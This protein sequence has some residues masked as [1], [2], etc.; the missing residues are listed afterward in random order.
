VADPARERSV[1]RYF[2]LADSFVQI[3]LTEGGPLDL[4]S[5]PGLNR[6]SYRRL[7]IE[8]CMPEFREDVAASIE[9]LFPEDPLMVEDLL[10]RLCVEINPAL[11]IHEVRL[12]VSPSTHAEQSTESPVAGPAVDTGRLARRAAALEAN[13]SKA[14]MGQ[15]RAVAAVARAVRKAAVGL[16]GEDRPLASF[17]FAG[18]TG[19][20]KTELARTLARQIFSEPGS[21]RGTGLVRVDCSEFALAHD[22][23]KLIG[24]PPGYVGHEEG[25]Q[26][27]EAVARTP[28]CVVLF[29]EIEKAHPRLH[30]LL[31]QVLE[32]G[33]LTDSKGQRVSF[34]RTIV[35]LTTNAGA[36]EMRAA[37]SPVGFGT[38]RSLAHTSLQSITTN[39]LNRE[40][41]PEFM[42]RIDET[43]LFD[44]LS[45]QSVE[46]IAARKL[47]E[48]A[49]RTREHGTTVAFTPAVARWVA[50]RGYSPESGA[51]ELRRVIQREVE[52]VI[53]DL[54]LENAISPGQLLRVRV[55][56]GKLAYEVED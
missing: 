24:A 48:L 55:R 38:A 1:F 36:Q 26:L 56:G 8:T 18:R 49:C 12:Q 33:A 15:G 2:D 11:D 28:E 42:G 5:R 45:C 7:V 46:R 41:S 20:G 25:G 16:A 53:V 6:A 10:Y 23:S 51:R 54:M 34:E 39:A 19:T 9:T 52:P 32:E 43:V 37:A 27:T 13:L 3:L 21:P 44:E 22:T 35:I 14:I 40:F 50:E 29:D 30:N 47:T 31:L 17:L 4:P